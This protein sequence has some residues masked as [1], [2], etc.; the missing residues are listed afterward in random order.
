MNNFISENIS[1][2]IK[3]DGLSLDDFGGLFDLSKGLT[4]Q[5][6]RKLSLPKIV[7]IQKICAYYKISIDDFINT[8]LSVGK[9]YATKGGNL[10]YTEEKR[11]DPYIISPR[12]VEVLEKSL[13]DKEKIIK[14]LELRLQTGEKSKTA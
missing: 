5:Y 6:A 9:P 3:K 1:F 4:G 8:D 7:T 14:S 10:L 13:E 11:P 2:L 12:Y